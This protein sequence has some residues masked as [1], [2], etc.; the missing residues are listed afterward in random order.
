MSA[1][2]IAIPDTNRH[3]MNFC[4]D[5]LRGFDKIGKVQL[6]SNIPA[7]ASRITVVGIFL[8]TLS[9]HIE[10]EVTNIR[11][12]ISKEISSVKIL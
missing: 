11:K 4:I 3:L 1:K 5:N 7:R 9:N 6:I 10:F 2:R 8:C 12:I